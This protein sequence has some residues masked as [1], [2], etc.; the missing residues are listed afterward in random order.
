MTSSCEQREVRGHD[1]QLLQELPDED[2]ELWLDARDR[3]LELE[4]EFSAYEQEL[5]FGGKHDDCDCV[6][7][8]GCECLFC[9]ECAGESEFI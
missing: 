3:L 8:D 4:A 1:L 5:L 7:C 9:K 2:E 6:M